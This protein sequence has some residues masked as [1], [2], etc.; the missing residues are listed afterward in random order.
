M[1]VLLPDSVPLA[2][3]LPDGVTG[4]VYDH[5]A[6][7]PEEHRDAEVLVFWG[8]SP[9]IVADYARTL[10]RLRLIQSL[11]AG[12][13]VLLK[14]G[15]ADEVEICSGAG[16][17][18]KTVSEHALALL[19][20]LVRRIPQAVRSQADHEWNTDI[21]GLQPLHPRGRIT[22]LLDARVLIWGFGSIGQHL[23]PML[24]LLGARV[25]GVA[26]SGG[27]RSGVEVIAESDLDSQLP[28]TDVL[29]MILPLTEQTAQALDA[30]RLELLPEQAYVINV[31]RGGNVDEPALIAAVESGSIAGAG[32][33][34]TSVEP[35]PADAPLWDAPNV[36]ITPH[37]AGGRPVDS[38]ALIEA[39][40]AALRSGRRLT[41]HVER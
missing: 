20:A 18:S 25:R 12:P 37:G 2:P 17:H 34:V 31:G 8:S 23:A 16:L 27:E 24:S 29:I 36:L 15:F 33:D 28:E 40:V 14:A 30:R 1:K 35:L 4:V 39:N 38:E 9:D 26:R 3:N 11:A 6:S 41:N 19:L 10:P 22:T 5:T 13:D 21:G 32:L 7:I